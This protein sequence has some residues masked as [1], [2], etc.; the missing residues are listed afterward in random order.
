MMR[1]LMSTLLP[2]GGQLRA[3]R[4]AWAAMSEGAQRARSRADAEVGV[5]TAAERYVAHGARRAL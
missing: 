2:A 1:D 3:R 5:S 4:N